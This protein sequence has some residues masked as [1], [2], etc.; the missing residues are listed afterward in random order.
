MGH[1]DFEVAIYEC[2]PS[3]ESKNADVTSR[4]ERRVRCVPHCHAEMAEGSDCE[5]E[6]EGEEEEEGEKQVKRG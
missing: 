3:F 2:H 4:S 1:V 6:E 5:K